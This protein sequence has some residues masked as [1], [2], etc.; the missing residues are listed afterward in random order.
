MRPRAE[1]F[2]Q[3]KVRELQAAVGHNP[4]ARRLVADLV[5]EWEREAAQPA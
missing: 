1:A 2:M 4:E 5:H 3:V